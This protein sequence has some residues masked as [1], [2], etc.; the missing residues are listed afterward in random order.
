MLVGDTMAAAGPTC[1]PAAEAGEAP[2]ACANPECGATTFSK[3]RGPNL[4][5]CSKSRCKALAAQAIAAAKEDT[6]DRRISELELKVREQATELAI[7][8]SQLQ[9]AQQASCAPSRSTSSKGAAGQPG[10][11]S[12]SGTACAGSRRPLAALPINTQPLAAR[13]HEPTA[14]KKAKFA[15]EPT[16]APPPPPPNPAIAF[17]RSEAPPGWTQSTSG[18]IHPDL[19]EETGIPTVLAQADAFVMPR[20]LLW[21][22]GYNILKAEGRAFKLSEVHTALEKILELPAGSVASVEPLH[23]AFKKVWRKAVKTI[24]ALLQEARDDV[25]DIMRHEPPEDGD[26][27]HEIAGMSD[28]RLTPP[29]VRFCLETLMKEGRVSMSTV[30]DEEHFKAV[31]SESECMYSPHTPAESPPP[32]EPRPTREVL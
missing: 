32:T 7:L 24:D 4:E 17:R 29:C 11:S 3:R 27:V 31:E 26:T 16:A 18:W 15:A 23:Q 12:G 2:W 21:Q 9:R 1:E 22:L 10:A 25:L 5:F 14:L 20:N 13:P 30:G 19:Q 6:K 28:S 8:R